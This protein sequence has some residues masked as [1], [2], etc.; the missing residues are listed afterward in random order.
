MPNRLF[1]ILTKVKIKMALKL[2]GTEALKLRE[3]AWR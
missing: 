3:D 2:S 1:Q